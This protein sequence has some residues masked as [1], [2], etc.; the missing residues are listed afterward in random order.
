MAAMTATPIRPIVTD[1]PDRRRYE[2]HVDDELAGV[3]EYAIPRGRIVMIHTEVLPK[4]E[5]RG[6]AA[7]IVRFALDDARRRNLRV[8]VS[9][10]YVDSYLKR[11]PKDND[12]VVGRDLTTAS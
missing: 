2:A 8:I 3:L 5:G 6:I 9:C 11:H 4:Y 12:L 1:A 10:P 7:A